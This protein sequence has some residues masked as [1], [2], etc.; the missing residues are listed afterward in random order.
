MGKDPSVSWYPGDYIGGT[1]GWTFEEKGAYVELLMAQFNRGH[2]DSHMVLHM[3]NQNNGLWE[4]I[5]SKFV[6]D[7]DGLWYN[8]RMDVE[9]EKRRKYTESRKRNLN[10]TAKSEKKSSHDMGSHMG[11]HM[12][13]EYNNNNINNINNNI[14]NNV[15]GI[16]KSKED[17]KKYLLGAEEWHEALAKNTESDLGTLYNYLKKFIKDQESAD[18]LYRPLDELKKHFSYYYKKQLKQNKRV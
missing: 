17:T 11:A 13:N 2:M 5:K 9:K 15:S 14:L 8:E 10:S 7:E 12:E 1:M 6:Q 18:A 4:R 16:F 3:L